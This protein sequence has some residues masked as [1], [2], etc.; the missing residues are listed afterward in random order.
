MRPR[1]CG[2]PGAIKHASS[3]IKTD[4]RR[5]RSSSK[6]E[7]RAPASAA[8]LRRASHR[9]ECTWAL[10]KLARS[11]R[12]SARALAARPAAAC[13]QLSSHAAVT[14]RDPALSPCPPTPES[15]P[16]GRTLNPIALPSPHLALSSA[17]PHA[18]D[19]ASGRTSSPS[20]LLSLASLSLAL[21]V[22]G[23][24]LQPHLLP[25]NRLVPPTPSV[26]QR[27]LVPARLLHIHAPS[28]LS[29]TFA[30]RRYFK[31]LCVFQQGVCSSLSLLRDRRAPSA[32]RRTPGADPP[33]PRAPAASF[34]LP[35][36]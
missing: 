29:V 11:R 18:E 1:K 13:S 23:A 10:A 3:A 16:R 19:T 4:R 21:V 8:C 28:I 31:P 5:A 12:H 30:R 25:L 9:S 7:G 26:R 24:R 15:V 6:E 14:G 36:A 27:H 20:S 32:A 35:S 22:A 34:F 2:A 33:S 17:P